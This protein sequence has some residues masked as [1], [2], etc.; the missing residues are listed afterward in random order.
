M[1]DVGSRLVKYCLDVSHDHNVIGRTGL[2]VF[3][4]GKEFLV[5][6]VEKP[7]VMM[8][9]FQLLA[10]E[11]ANVEHFQVTL[12][13]SH[14]I[15]MVLKFLIRIF[16]LREESFGD[17]PIWISQGKS[18]FSEAD[19]LCRDTEYYLW[20]PEKIKRVRASIGSPVLDQDLRDRVSMSIFEVY[21]GKYGTIISFFLGHFKGDIWITV[22]TEESVSVV[23]FD[24]GR[25]GPLGPETDLLHYGGPGEMKIVGHKYKF[26]L[27]PDC[28]QWKVDDKNYSF[29][30]QALVSDHGNN[31]A[32]SYVDHPTWAEKDISWQ[33][34]N[35]WTR[36]SDE[37]K[38]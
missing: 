1:Q 19:E 36:Q 2:R 15:E 9:F 27:N 8:G 32:I 25:I 3:N 29:V 30:N 20:S 13:H 33:Q 24:A 4:Y 16:P 17:V 37:W 26:S 35:A 22:E 5:R 7:E 14:D 6:A 10:G 12:T 34:E 11:V 28:V 38:E 31:V 18:F 21:D 23:S